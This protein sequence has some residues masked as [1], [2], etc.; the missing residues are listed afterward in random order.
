VSRAATD[1]HTT[2]SA[3]SKMIK[4]LEDELGATIFL[5]SSV[6]ITGLTEYGHEFMEV[7]R[8]VLRDAEFVARRARDET[9]TTR[10]LLRIA[11][12]HNH[13]TY[14]LPRIVAA[15]RD[16]YPDVSIELEQAEGHEVARL[17][18]SRRVQMGLA[19]VSG[20]P[21]S[22]LIKLPAMKLRRSI[23]MPLGHDLLS[24]ATPTMADIARYPIVAHDERHPAGARLRQLFKRHN[25]NA[26]IVVTAPDA[27]TIK[28]YV[29]AGVGIA[30]LLNLAIRPED[31]AKL[32]L[33]DATHLIPPTETHLIFRQGEHLRSYVY[34]FAQAFSSQW[35][36]RAI[37]TEM[38]RQATWN[39]SRERED[40][41]AA[42]DSIAVQLHEVRH[43]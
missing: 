23:V 29:A 14:S 17:V 43:R 28:E 26:R 40:L 38:E 33:I 22:G 39:V 21:H 41:L 4:A 7:A 32:S 13:A 36:K 27:A 30:I 20:Q 3:V 16:K 5:R 8:G 42:T 24:I 1:L 9:C 25:V 12:A 18:A 11:A 37:M 15:F 34:D 19:D 6:R 10:G 31:D 2:Q 35:S